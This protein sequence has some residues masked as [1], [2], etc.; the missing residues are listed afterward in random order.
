M[1]FTDFEFTEVVE[2][3]VKL[4]CCTT[5]DD[6]TGETLE[7]WLHNDPFMQMELAS[8][9]NKNSNEIY[10]GYMATAESRSFMALGLDPVSFKWVDGFLEYRCLTNHNKNLSYGDQL[11]NGQIKKTKKPPPKWQRTEEDSINGFRPTHSLAEATFKL[12]GQVRDTEHKDIMR[13]LIISNPESFTE[14]EKKLVQEYCTEDVIHL[15]KIYSEIINQFKIALGKRCN[16]EM[17]EKEM[18]LRGKYAALTAKMESRGYPIDFQKTKN[19]SSSVG[20]LLDECQREINE[21]FPEIKPFRYER[22]TRRFSMNTRNIKEW[23]IKNVDT[24]KWM[25]TD[26]GDLSLSL[27]AWTNFY[28][29]KHEYPKDNFGA[30]MVRYLKLKQNLNGFVPSASK[31][32][33][34]FWGAVGSDKRVRP[35]FNPY[36]SIG[37]RSQPGS[38]SFLFLKPA[39]MRSLCSPQKGRAIASIDY[40]S[41]EFFISALTSNCKNMID[42]Y[43]SG[44]VYLYFA[45]LAKAVPMDGAREQYKKERNIFKAV[46][47]SISYMQTAKGLS[48]KLSEETGEEFTETQAQILIDKFYASYPEFRGNQI[49]LA[50]KYKTESKL[51]LPCGWYLFGD[52]D[53]ERSSGNF[54]IQGFGASIMRKAVEM[55][56]EAGLETI[57]T[58]HDALY[59]EYDSGDFKVLDAFLKIMKE[60]FMFYFPEELKETAS[61]IKMDLFSWSPDY[62][63][64]STIITPNGVEVAV[65]DIYVDDRSVNEFNQFKKYFENRIED[66]YL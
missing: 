23:L 25:E 51:K 11:V 26:N 30:Q 48:R 39:W 20:P 43:L 62:Q 7:W 53:N 2:P 50:A 52:N 61:K 41:E 31:N 38:T 45:K 10:F 8:Y 47:L 46:T 56:E 42:A 13:D 37:S 34:N 32:K 15:P 59:I 65:T 44:D 35:Y 6:K 63:K 55:A 18:L 21:L 3:V 64:D 4:V 17:L 28:D 19:F 58:L 16:L 66:D 27:D 49:K 33:K 14:E 54:N 36:G 29:F 22:K 1:I 12:T 5:F 57:V 40:G 24:K 60:A 9:L